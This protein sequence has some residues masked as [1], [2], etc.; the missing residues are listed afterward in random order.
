MKENMD[1]GDGISAAFPTH[2][3]IDAHSAEDEILGGM[4]KTLADSRLIKVMVDIEQGDL[5]SS[6]VIKIVKG[7]GFSMVK[8]IL[9][10]GGDVVPDSYKCVFVR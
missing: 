1:A 3:F 7:H 9:E 6:L 5:D 4:A 2:I 8:S 10:S